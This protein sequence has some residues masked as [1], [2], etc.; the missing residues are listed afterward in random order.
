MSTEAD[1]IDDL[2]GSLGDALEAAWEQT[3][4]GGETHDDAND[5][6]T[7]IAAAADAAAAPAEPEPA[8]PGEADETAAGTVP[9]PDSTKPGE[10]SGDDGPPVS[11]PPAAREAWKD[12]PPAMREA[13]TKREADFEAG[14][15][16][17]SGDAKRATQMD[18]V[19]QPFQQYF[20]MDGGNPANTIT[21]LLQTAS[22]LQMG[23]PVQKAQAAAQ[24]IQRFGVDINT[25]ADT[26]DGV[27]PQGG[28]QG[29]QQAITPESIQRMIQQG[30]AQGFQGYQQQQDQASAQTSLEKFLATKPE[31]YHDVA[32]DM[33]DY[34]DMQHRRGN[35]VTYEQAYEAA[36]NMRA[37][38]RNILQARERA[39]SPSQREAAASITGAPGGA[40]PAAMGNGTLDD[41]LASA[42]AQHSGGGL[43]RI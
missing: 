18:Q 13:I 43:A 33:A 6:D 16:K 19:L 26:L 32:D 24:I 12:T 17:Y 42:W 20:A 7:D 5:I 30:V 4:S 38:I 37:D 36:C 2:G 41:D 40:D 9:K 8:S 15:L 31:F 23:S 14:I 1:N 11:L 27:P 29:G 22:L 34:I 25:L 39:P 10:E 28:Q 35:Q 3:E 21:G